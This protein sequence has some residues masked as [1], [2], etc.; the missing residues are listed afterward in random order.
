MDLN[1]RDAILRA[2]LL[3]LLDSGAAHLD[4]ES[5]VSGL[6]PSLWGVRPKGLPHSPWELLEHL[7]ICQRDILDFCL[8]ADFARLQWPYDYWPNKATV[9]DDLAWDRSVASFRT[10]AQEMRNLI[11]DPRTDLLRPLAWGT[12]QSIAREAMLLADHNAYHLGHLVVVRRLL[13]AWRDA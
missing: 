2:H 6:D 1:N 13:G 8:S 10:D 11:V 9:P 7:R 12:G 3:E 5:A 4:F